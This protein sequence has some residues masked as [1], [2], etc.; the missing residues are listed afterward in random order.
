M[1]VKVPG[2]EANLL[3]SFAPTS[4][5]CNITVNI[6]GLPYTHV[7]DVNSINHWSRKV[8]TDLGQYLSDGVNSLTLYSMLLLSAKMIFVII[9]FS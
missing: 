9:F 6:V 5:A 1:N 8:L 3:H 2:V 4:L 7:L